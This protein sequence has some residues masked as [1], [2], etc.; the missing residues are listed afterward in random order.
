MGMG[1]P[2]PLLFEVLDAL[3]DLL[4]D[5]ESLTRSL[6]G[7]DSAEGHQGQLPPSRFSARG[8]PA[9]PR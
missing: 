5:T 3:D 4:S 8:G 7:V 1:G 6:L 9:P 2:K